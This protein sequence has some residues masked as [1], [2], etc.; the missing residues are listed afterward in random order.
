MSQSTRRNTLE[1][2]L[3]NLEAQQR[4]IQRRI[5]RTQIELELLNQQEL[6]QSFRTRNIQL[7]N[8]RSN[9][10]TNNSTSSDNNS[11][12]DDDNNNDTDAI[13]N[14]PSSSD[15][16]KETDSENDQGTSAL[17]H[18]P[19]G[20]SIRKGYKVSIQKPLNDKT[21]GIIIGSTPKR[22]RIRLDNGDIILRQ[23]SNL[24][25]FSSSP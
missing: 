1:D 12:S 4:I 11:D 16:S 17:F 14:N 15:S 7:N 3:T 23:P 22:L 19:D 2:R 10:S 6:E 25:P 24:R 18:F 8:Q 21:S 5:I 9:P 20:N 13:E